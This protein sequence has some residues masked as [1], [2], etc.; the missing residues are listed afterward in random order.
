MANETKYEGDPSYPSDSDKQKISIKAIKGRPVSSTKRNRATGLVYKWK[1]DVRSQI[2]EKIIKGELQKILHD[3]NAN[4]HVT[5]YICKKER[6][7]IADV[8][9]LLKPFLDSLDKKNNPCDE[10]LISDDRNFRRIVAEREFVEEM[11]E[12]RVE[13]EYVLT[14]TFKILKVEPIDTLS[15][16]SKYRNYW[17]HA[18]NRITAREIKN[19]KEGPQDYVFIDNTPDRIFVVSRDIPD[20]ARAKRDAT[21]SSREGNI[22]PRI[23]PPGYNWKKKER[24][25]VEGCMVF[26][27]KPSRPPE[28]DQDEIFWWLTKW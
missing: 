9:N 19:Q 21:W 13:L 26:D 27:K 28:G 25:T 23:I 10:R 6:S 7:E 1:D 14:K 17:R 24:K 11:D 15:G 8:D 4:L 22:N 18:M 20:L 16:L 12:E 2:N 3:A 5:F